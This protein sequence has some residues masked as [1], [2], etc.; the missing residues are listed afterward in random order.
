MGFMSTGHRKNADKTGEE[1]GHLERMRADNGRN[2]RGFQQVKERIGHL[3]S[4][5]S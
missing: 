3:G 2:A 1:R 5:A 4:S